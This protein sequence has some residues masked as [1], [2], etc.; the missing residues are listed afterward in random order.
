[1][2]GRRTATWLLLLLAG[3]ASP[4]RGDELEYPVKAEFIERFTRF[5]D[6]P[7]DSG[8]GAFVL[9]EVG[10]S[11]LDPY[12]S[13]LARER[14]IKERAVELRRLKPGADPSGCHV[15]FIAAGERQHLKTIVS[16]VEGKPIL[17]VADAEGFARDGVLINLFVDEDGRVRFEINPTRLRKSGLTVSAQLLRLARLVEEQKP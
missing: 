10:D 16:R 11:P 2:G 13:R 8:D 17:T 5:V 15:L 4:A 1:M 3:A 14:R 12:L 6:W 7:G 9:C